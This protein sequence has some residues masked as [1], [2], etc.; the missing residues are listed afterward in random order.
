M[1]WAVTRVRVMAARLSRLLAVGRAGLLGRGEGVEAVVGPVGEHGLERGHDLLVVE[2]LL[3]VE[4][5][6]AVGVVVA[7]GEQVDVPVV[8]HRPD[9]RVEVD[10][11]VEEVPG[12]VAHERLEEG[13]DGHDVAARRPLDVGEVLVAAEAEPPEPEGGVPVLVAFADLD[14]GV[15][16][17]HR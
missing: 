16:G 17:G 7:A 5:G 11:A 1:R 15:G 14:G 6:L 13:L 2:V 8:V 12:H 10:D 4:L 3:V 9:H